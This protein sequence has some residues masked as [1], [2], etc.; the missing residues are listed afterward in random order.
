VAAGF[1]LFG[2]A[3]L[4]IL[5]ATVVS[6]AA[7]ILWARR[8]PAHAWTIA[9]MLG[10]FLAVNETVW[11]VYRYSTEGIRI[12]G[13]PLQLCDA[14]VWI[15]ALALVR[16]VQW[17]F[18]FAYFAGL[19]G[20][21]MALVTPDLWAPLDSYPSIYYFLVHAALVTGVVY[22]IG[23]RLL[24]P[25]PGCLRR[26]L[27]TVNIYAAVVGGFNAAFRTNYM[28]LCRK[29]QGASL[30]DWFGPWPVYILVGEVAALALCW[31]LWLPFA[32]IARRPAT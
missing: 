1:R 19:A 15:T 3:H 20:A 9:A 29:P 16:R 2:F 21:G 17:A 24:R 5:A 25:R 27:I 13:L 28:Y 26:F 10:V 7:L 31:L 18:E 8:R 22:P 30:L 4:A 11:Y 6:A 23:A 14:A 12:G 32:R